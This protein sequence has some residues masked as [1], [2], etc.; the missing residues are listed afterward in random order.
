MHSEKLCQDGTQRRAAE[1]HRP[2]EGRH[3]KQPTFAQNATNHRDMPPLSDIHRIANA[4]D[5]G[6]SA[7]VTARAESDAGPQ[8][9]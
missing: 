6:C 4:C 2:V 8:I 5:F 9:Q 1:Q 7:E 3:P